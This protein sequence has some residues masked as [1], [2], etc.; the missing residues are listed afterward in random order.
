MRLVTRNATYVPYWNEVKKLS[1][2]K[3]IQLI[4]L[5]SSSLI[6]EVS[7]KQNRTE[8]FI[9]RCAGSWKGN[10]TAE[11]LIAVIEEGRKS[12]TEPVEL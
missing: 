8:E 11:E 3:K 9:A 6:E 12:K 5:L 4:A 10:Q 2:E 1:N 7:Q